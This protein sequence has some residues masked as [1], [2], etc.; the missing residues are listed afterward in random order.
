MFHFYAENETSEQ[1][2]QETI[3]NKTS[4]QT[5]QETCQ[6]PERACSISALDDG[7]TKLLIF[8]GVNALNG[9]VP[10]P[11]VL[12]IRPAFIGLLSVNALNGLVPFPRMKRN[13]LIALLLCVNALNGL[14][15]FPLNELKKAKSENNKV[16]MP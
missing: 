5:E 10:F 13:L 11:P 16:S 6:C 15:P 3:A 2:E 8:Y 9:L 1:T 7:S 14:V 12:L 4:E